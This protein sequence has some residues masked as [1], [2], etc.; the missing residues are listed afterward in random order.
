M[1]WPSNTPH[2][3][4]Y[5]S[6][7]VDTTGSQ[8]NSDYKLLNN[9]LKHMGID[10]RDVNFIGKIPSERLNDC[11]A[12]INQLRERLPAGHRLE[13]IYVPDKA[14]SPR[15]Q[16]Y[17][18][19]LREPEQRQ[20]QRSREERAPAQPAPQER[21]EF[22][23]PREAP[24]SIPRE[25]ANAFS[26]PAPQRATNDDGNIP[27]NPSSGDGDGA[28]TT[29]QPASSKND[30]PQPALPSQQ[31][32]AAPTSLPHAQRNQADR[33][34]PNTNKAAIN[35]PASTEV[36][37]T[38][39]R[40]ALSNRAPLIQGFGISGEQRA[41]IFQ[42][43]ILASMLFQSP[44]GSKDQERTPSLS[45]LNQ[46]LQQTRMVDQDVSK[47]WTLLNKMTAEGHNLS[48]SEKVA[49]MTAM[50]VLAKQLNALQQDA[51]HNFPNLG[52]SKGANPLPA[53]PQEAALLL[54]TQ[55]D[56]LLAQLK[57]QLNENISKLADQLNNKIAMAS[58]QATAAEKGNA[59]TTTPQ[60]VLEGEVAT[61]SA[62]D[63]IKPL[64][65][66]AA[67]AA[68]ILA[69][70]SAE[71]KSMTKPTVPLPAILQSHADLQLLADKLQKR[72]LAAPLNIAIVYP[73]DKK[74]MSQ[75]ISGIK[76]QKKGK[77]DE[78]QST[79]GEAGGAKH[80]QEM[81]LVSAGPALIEGPFAEQ[82]HVVELKDF[83]IATHLVTNQQFAD[84]LNEA[85]S[86]GAIKL[87]EKGVIYDQHRQLL[88]KTHRADTTSQIQVEV[89]EGQL[90]FKP[91]KGTEEHPVVQVSHLGAESYCR[92][93][94][95]RLPTEAE[96]E[97]AAGTPVLRED[98]PL[99]KFRYGFGKNEID[100]SW[101]NYRDELRTYNDN[102]TTPIGF[103]NGRSVFT[104]QAKNYQSRD[105]RS[106]FGCYDMSGNV[107]QWTSGSQ[108]NKQVAKGGSYNSPPAELLVAARALLDPQAC[109]ADTGFRVTLDI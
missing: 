56:V 12:I 68:E 84:W 27:S 78:R 75:N 46:L 107:R 2:D 82:A 33:A 52:T 65:M 59:T 29:Q 6:F 47:L 19:T 57:G 91:L 80:H 92:A 30:S 99:S 14:P 76:T 44:L 67:N 3:R 1:V 61:P 31:N 58:G 79:Q 64:T 105:A 94:N 41:L 9:V 28:Q 74:E 20:P 103:Y 73:L 26:Q 106:P 95:F 104:K 85:L 45:Q 72:E 89:L 18:T 97:K 35:T 101:A 70:T 81:V 23:E 5:P 25:D 86:A 69:Q 10:H 71:A 102:R 49:I 39:T 108:E 60:A 93:N 63:G 66:N 90:L 4:P 98:E 100:L 96:W 11:G 36:I 53:N 32:Q 42:Q 83:L 43:V 16:N 13:V 87:D 34:T 62:K 54:K 109:Y 22:I 7:R 50:N 38:T 24:R 51:T 40:E 88:C 55:S 17:Q 21:I 48:P 37:T 77:G 8:L 15:E